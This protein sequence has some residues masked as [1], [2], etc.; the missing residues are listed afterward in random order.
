MGWTSVTNR[1]GVS[2]LAMLSD[3]SS[4]RRGATWESEGEQGKRQIEVEELAAGI[5]GIFGILKVTSL[6]TGAV[7]RTALVVLVKR[8]KDEFFW[9][10]MTE[11]EG[12]YTLGI[13]QWMF[14]KLSAPE[15]FATGNSLEYVKRWR[16]EV[17]AYHR[18]KNQIVKPGNVLEFK[19][20]LRFSLSKGPVEVKR[21]RVVSWGAKK[22][23]E[24]LCDDGNTF[25]CLLRRHSLN[26][27]YSVQV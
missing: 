9:K 5:G 13:P 8:E 1:R 10:T 23:F 26:N 2:S 20:S 7:Y 24:A 25:P 11:S 4:Y 18:K 12:P 14:N 21:F 16:E 22:R 19:D 27:T 15:E 17:K 3:Y 6:T